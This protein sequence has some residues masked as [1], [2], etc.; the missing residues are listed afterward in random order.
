MLMKITLHGIHFACHAIF[1]LGIK[2]VLWLHMNFM[3]VKG[4]KWLFLMLKVADR[5]FRLQGFYSL[6]I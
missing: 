5:W 1:I 6:T 4:S 3:Q 2:Q